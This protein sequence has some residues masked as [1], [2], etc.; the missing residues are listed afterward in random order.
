MDPN[1]LYILIIV[2][3]FVSLIV[4]AS[5]NSKFT[6]LSQVPVSTGMTGAEAA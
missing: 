5:V 3:F 1:T 2:M 6:R 4:Q